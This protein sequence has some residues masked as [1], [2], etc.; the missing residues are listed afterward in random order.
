M[1]EEKKRNWHKKLINYL[2]E[3]RVSTKKY[4]G[5]SPFQL[6]YGVD[7]VFPTSLAVPMMKIL[8]EVDSEPNDIQWRINQM[9]HL[10]QSMEEVF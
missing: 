10:Q 4:I 5:M 2:W 3:D 6:V 8:Q 9:I 1:L 7:M